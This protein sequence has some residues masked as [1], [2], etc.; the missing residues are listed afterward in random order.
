[1]GVRLFDRTPEGLL[2]TAFAIE[3]AA[4]AELLESHRADIGRLASGQEGAPQ[5]RIRVA[6]PDGLASSW[7]LPALS[8]F[9][10]RYPAI[11]LDLV[12]GHSVVDLVRR[13][14]DLALRFVRPTSADLVVARVG[15]VPLA[16]YVHP[17]LAG[18]APGSLRWIVFDD[19]FGRYLETQW[20][21]EHVG[22]AMRMR[23]SLW[24]AL[25]AGVAHGL[26][27]GIVSPL[28]AEPA[29][30]VALADLPPV[31]SRPL[32][33]VYHRALRDVPR[34]AALRAWLVGNAGAM[35]R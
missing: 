32:Y 4:H 23:V 14:A 7:L 9:F 18:R 20:V 8:S 26:G 19:P 27:A 11:E 29:G 16:P 15:D 17:S 33:L 10:E 34:I 5:G 25:F 3:L 12:I 21:D 35:L 28:V 24:N 1:M 31:P 2:P 22:D 6:L 13:E 30:L